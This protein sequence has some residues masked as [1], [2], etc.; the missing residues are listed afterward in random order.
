MLGAFFDDS[1]THGGSPVVAIGGLLG[2]EEQWEVFAKAWADLLA[3][4]LPGKPA[5]TQFHLSPCRA[6]SGEFQSYNLAERDRVTYLFRRI[7]LNTGL[8]TIASAVDLRAWNELITGAVADQFGEP[9]AYCFVKCVDLVMDICQLQRPGEKILIFFDEGTKDGL[10][11]W[12]GFYRAQPHRYPSLAAMT[13]V[14]VKKVVALQGA[15]MVALE[16][17]QYAQAWLKDRAAPSPNPHFK[18][19]VYRDLSVGLIL[20]REQIQ[21]MVDRVREVTGLHS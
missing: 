16:T 17:Y 8:V 15:D 12:A 5:L 11:K 7:I 4:P 14:S 6:G 21:E 18:D 10:E 13:F 2:T 20:G 9:L 19:F 3:A 1:G